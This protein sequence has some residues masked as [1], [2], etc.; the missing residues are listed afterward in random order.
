MT[1]ST[2]DLKIFRSQR[3]RDTA[4]GGGAMSPTEV[5]DGELNNVFDDISSQDRVTGR[6]SFRKVF[7]GAYSNNTDRYFGAGLVIVAPADDAAVD[8]LMTSTGDFADERADVVQRVVTYLIPGQTLRW[9]LFNDHLTG[10]NALTL[11]APADTESPDL[12]DT[13]FLEDRDDN[14]RSEAV[15]IQSIVSRSAQT[16]FDDNGAFQRDVLVVQLSRPL[17]DDWTGTEVL[18]STTGVAPTR[19]RGST[20][21]SGAKYSGVKAAGDVGAGD[22]TISVADP[23]ARVVPS[24]K[25]ET[26]ITDEPAALEGASFAKAGNDNAISIST[27]SVSYGAGDSNSFFLGGSVMPGSVQVSGSVTATDNGSGTLQFGSAGY[28]GTIDYVAGEVQITA[29]SGGSLSFSMTATPAAAVIDANQSMQIAVE[30]QTRFN[31]YIRTLEPAPAP[32]TISVDY[33]ALGNWYRLTDN[34]SGVLSGATAGEGGGTVNYGTG[35]V[36]ATLAALPDVGTDIIISW[37]SV[38]TVVTR[39]QYPAIDPPALSFTVDEPGIAPG[40][41]SADYLS[42]GSPVTVE[43][44]GNGAIVPA[45]GGAALGGIVYATGEVEFTPSPWPDPATTLNYSYDLDTGEQQVF[46]PSVSGDALAQVTFTLPNAPLRPGSV[47]LTWEASTD[48]FTI[49]FAEFVGQ[50]P[51][52]VQKTITARDNG[53]GGFAGFAGS[54]INYTT[55]E[56]SLSTVQTLIDQ[57]YPMIRPDTGRIWAMGTHPVD[58]GLAAGG[59]IVAR[60]QVASAPTVART[61]SVTNPPFRVQL[62]PLTND[63]LIEGSIRFTLNGRTYVDRRGSLVSDPDPNTNAGTLAGSVNYQ[64][65]EVVISD[66]AAGSFALSVVGM[67][68]RAGSVPTSELYFRTPVAPLAQGSLTLQVIAYESESFD[69]TAITATTDINGNISG[70]LI[71]GTVDFENGIVAVRF[72]ETVVAAGNE[73]EWWFDADNVDDSGNIW[74]PFLIAPGSA[75]FSAVGFVS[76]PLDP[77]ILGLDPIRLP[78]DGRVPIFRP[79]DTL[80]V[81]QRNSVEDAAPSAG[82]V[83]D[84]GIDNVKWV[85]VKDSAGAEVLSEHYT[86]NGETGEL[87]WSNPLDLAAYAA[88]F[89]LDSMAYFMRLCTDVEINGTIS[90]AAPAPF[91]LSNTNAPVFLSSKLI[92]T[93]DGGNQDLQGLVTNFFTQDS[94]TNEWSN[95]VIGSGT[96]GQFDDATYPI[97]MRNDGSITERWRLEFTGSG[98]VNVIG[99]RLGQIVTGASIAATIAP[100]NPATGQPYFSINPAGWSGGWV[101]GNQVRFNT[102]GANF[103]VWLI[104]S[105][106]PGDPGEQLQDRFIAHLMGDVAQ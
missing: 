49:W 66:Y 59:N 16:F 84:L 99:E 37:G 69:Q 29:L 95:Q 82:A 85:R 64:T 63:H 40:S 81:S 52:L 80:L 92:F 36:T 39:E 56:V 24:T 7:P 2:T 35:T 42:G 18:R 51:R 83:V 58:V 3:N 77:Q 15:K 91:A 45:G 27:G 31:N 98:S 94:W 90:M 14:T 50:K 19:L 96:T 26:P 1:I 43:D 12:G 93:P 55:G 72:G 28:V 70:P 11:Y 78:S 4:D 17:Q 48:Y 79:G 8:V 106:Q 21:S 105:T 60:W 44:D 100:V 34:G 88:P 38:V 65:G 5:I 74:K 73:S 53:A 20:V 71:S 86:V 13:V 6:V 67:G 30:P 87:V 46:T 57:Q 33:R 68:V 103:P 25:A 47:T 61:G 62:A 101:V 54:S 75:R 104:R 32:G 89:T 22:S 41:F 97:E 9:R 10:T 23:F 102:L 76:I